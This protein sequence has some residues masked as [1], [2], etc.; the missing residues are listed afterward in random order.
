MKKEANADRPKKPAGGAFGV[1]L[2]KNRTEMQKSLP[3]GSL[4]TAVAPVASA[5][6]KTMNEADKA[7][8]NEEYLELKSK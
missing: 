7:P 6:W 4:C 1:W 5:I 2:N 3:E 8:L